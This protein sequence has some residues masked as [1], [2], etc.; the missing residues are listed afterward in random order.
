MAVTQSLGG[1]VMTDAR[2]VTRLQMDDVRRIHQRYL[3]LDCNPGVGLAQ[4]HAIFASLRTKDRMKIFEIFSQET[5]GV[6]SRR[7]SGESQALCLDAVKNLWNA[8]LMDE[9]RVDVNEVIA[10]SIVTAAAFQNVK[11]RVLF[12]LYDADGSG[13]LSF[14]EV[15]ILV[16]SALRGLCR[17]TG[18][19]V[20][21]IQVSEMICQAAFSSSD[22]DGDRM[23]S[24]DEWSHF[25]RSDKAI[26]SIIERFS[27]KS[28]AENKDEGEGKEEFA[29]SG[30][31]K[32][33]DKPVPNPNMMKRRSSLHSHPNLIRELK[34]ELR[35]LRDVFDSIDLDG[36]GDIP[37]EE[38]MNA[39]HTIMRKNAASGRVDSK[40]SIGPFQ[41][42]MFLK[43][44][45]NG[46][47]CV[48]WQELISV[49]YHK[50]GQKVIKE[51][52]GWDLSAASLDKPST[53]SA[54]KLNAS[55]VG[56]IKQMFAVYDCAGQGPLYIMD[57]A[58]K[59][60]E[61]HGLD[62]HD[63]MVMFESLGKDAHDTIDADAY[64]ELFKELIVG[65]E[66]MFELLRKT[67]ATFDR[68]PSKSEAKHVHGLA[69]AKQD[70]ESP[71]RRASAYAPKKDTESPLRRT[72]T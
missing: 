35:M 66:G 33:D 31:A 45:K 43:M 65:D 7:N 49:M 2:S 3:R 39:N 17:I 34:K 47:G 6:R 11:I 24:R 27:L 9:R 1:K 22:T 68:E 23:V 56:E 72:S 18:G 52:C 64:V 25:C 62:E 30:D 55:Q 50:Y 61:L 15:V 67:S 36:S 41:L 53:S 38:F 54:V 16:G 20:P 63:L 48:S 4:F 5:R 29:E 13:A 71:R 28:T 32:S 42:D 10:V 21:D 19:H 40:G 46:D 60:A 26:L 51:M 14:A 8:E 70:A 59:M 69:N 58:E 57:L 37:L 44:D 12:E